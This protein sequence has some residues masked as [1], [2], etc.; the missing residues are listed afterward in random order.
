MKYY[1]WPGITW[2]GNVNIGTGG[3]K[4][5]NYLNRLLQLSQTRPRPD[6]VYGWLP[7][8]VYGGNGL[9]W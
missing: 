6:H 4:L 5:L 1:P 2:G 8:S 3:I 7:T 9:A